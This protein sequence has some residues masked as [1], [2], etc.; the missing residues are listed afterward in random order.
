MRGYFKLGA[1]IEPSFYMLKLFI[2]LILLIA[3]NTN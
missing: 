2:L 3:Q 1:K